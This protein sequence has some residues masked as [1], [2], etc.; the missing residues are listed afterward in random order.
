MEEILWVKTYNENHRVEI[1]QYGCETEKDMDNLAN[2]LNDFFK[3]HRD[4]DRTNAEVNYDEVKRC[5]LCGEVYETMYDHKRKAYVCANCG[6]G[7][8]EYSIKIL[9]EAEEKQKKENRLR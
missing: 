3:E 9:A 6:K 1:N 2:E 5:I 8:L 7:K 4:W